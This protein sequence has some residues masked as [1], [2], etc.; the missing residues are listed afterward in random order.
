M[1]IFHMSGRLLC[2]LDTLFS[3]LFTTILWSRP[4]LVLFHR[5]RNRGIERL[6]CSPNTTE[7]ADV[8]YK[9][10]LFWLQSLF[11]LAYWV[12]LLCW[13]HLSSSASFSRYLSKSYIMSPLG[14]CIL[15][16][17]SLK[18]LTHS[19]EI[20]FASWFKQQPGT[21]NW[22]SK[23]LWGFFLPNFLFWK[24]LNLSESFKNNATNIHICST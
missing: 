4:Y 12:L 20:I 18:C 14:A 2:A 17:I 23:T 6:S 15:S 11:C 24:I 3:L 5:C 19:R 9:P 7:L 8:R 1:N 16:L 13:W 10:S 21:R 22:I